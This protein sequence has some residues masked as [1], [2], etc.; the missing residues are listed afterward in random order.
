[1]FKEGECENGVDVDD[2]KACEEGRGCGSVMRYEWCGGKRLVGVWLGVGGGRGGGGG[3][4][5]G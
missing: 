1:M 4:G 3:V 5:R 2:R